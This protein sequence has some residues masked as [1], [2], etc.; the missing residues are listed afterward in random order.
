M[1]RTALLAGCALLGLFAI[2]PSFGADL[3]QPRP[4]SRGPIYQ[5]AYVAPFTWQGFYATVDAGYGWSSS[6]LTA[7]GMS[8]TVHPKGAVLSGGFGYNFQAGSLVF[9]V[10]GDSGPSWMRDTNAAAAP[11]ASCEVRNHYLATVRGRLGYAFDNWL[12]YATAGAAFGD[13]TIKTPAGGSQGE[14]KVGWTAGAGLE[15]AFTGTRWSTKL[16]YLYVNLGSATCDA[17]HCGVSTTADLK[18][19]V[20][21]LGLNYKF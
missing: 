20:V 10:E 2:N 7:S 3:A 8:T 14:N 17:M 12:P 6:T 5:P 18:A 11:C 16:E 13:I 1:N 19:N 9:G 15:Y 4:Y 21:R